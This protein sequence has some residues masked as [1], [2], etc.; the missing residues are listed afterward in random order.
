MASVN[1]CSVI[2][3][4]VLLLPCRKP[5]N[6][7]AWGPVIKWPVPCVANGGYPDSDDEWRIPHGGL[8]LADAAPP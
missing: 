7:S 2:T 1:A 4:A 6:C 8:S 5:T 3:G